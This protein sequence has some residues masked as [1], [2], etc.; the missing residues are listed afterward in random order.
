[1]NRGVKVPSK[2]GIP[3]GQK[4][5]RYYRQRALRDP[6][7]FNTLH[8]T[9]HGILLRDMKGGREE[10]FD[11][12]TRVLSSGTMLL[13]GRHCGEHLRSPSETMAAFELFGFCDQRD[14][15]VRIEGLCLPCQALETTEMLGDGR[16]DD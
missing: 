3:H 1:L 2:G 7:I 15:L 11:A 8:N 6:F 9:Y 10:I 16:F 13:F 5:C 14:D 12:V 4:D